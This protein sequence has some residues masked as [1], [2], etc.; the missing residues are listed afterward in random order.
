MGVW[1]LAEG[2]A[3]L[4]YLAFT[5]GPSL[6]SSSGVKNAWSFTSD[7]LHKSRALCL[8]KHKDN[9]SVTLIKGI[10]FL[11]FYSPC[12]PGP[13]V[14]FPNLYT[15]GSIPWTHDKSVARPLPTH[16]ATQTQNKRTQTSMLEWDSLKVS[17][18][19]K[20]MSLPGFVPL[21]L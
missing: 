19:Y 9:F 6:P 3:F 8:I 2:R 15:V 12:G 17:Q 5:A 11:W 4:F 18:V 20:A 7:H 1:F 21:T 13:L 16:R 10:L 14:H